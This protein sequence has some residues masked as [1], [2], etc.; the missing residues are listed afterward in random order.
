[1]W[2]VFEMR[3]G[4]GCCKWCSK[5]KYELVCFK[6]SRFG[7]RHWFCSAEILSS[8]M[9]HYTDFMH[10]V[11]CC[12]LEEKKNELK[13]LT[14]PLI[15]LFVL[16]HIFLKMGQLFFPSCQWNLHTV[17]CTHTKKFV[18]DILL[19]AWPSQALLKKSYPLQALDGKI[20][21]Q[22]WGL[23]FNTRSYQAPLQRFPTTND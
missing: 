15:A 5:K 7:Q 14:D 12:P 21:Q 9:I 1:M 11:L 20:V 18:N 3:R 2:S 23:C 4:G 6:I 10:F 19:K 17:Q 22:L 13:S 16:S 8:S